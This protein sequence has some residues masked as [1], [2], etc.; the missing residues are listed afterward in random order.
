MFLLKIIRTYAT[1]FLSDA[2]QPEVEFFHPGIV[3]WVK[4]SGESSL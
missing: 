4:L 1:A 2:R 3:V